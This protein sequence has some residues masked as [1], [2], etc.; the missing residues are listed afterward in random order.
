[1]AVRKLLRRVCLRFATEPGQGA[2]WSEYRG[3]NWVLPVDDT[4]VLLAYD[5]QKQQRSIVVDQVDNNVYELATFDRRV[6]SRPPFLDKETVQDT[7]IWWQKWLFEVTAG[8]I[9]EF[10]KME[11]DSMHLSLR[12]EYDSNRSAAGYGASGLRD[13]FVMGVDIYADGERITPAAKIEDIPENGHIVASGTKIEA[14]R[15]MKVISGTAS[16]FQC[17]SIDQNMIK[18]PRAGS[19][20][21]RHMTE[22]DYQTEYRSPQ[23]LLTRYKTSLYDIARLLQLTGSATKITGPDGR[24]NSALTLNSAVDLENNAIAGDY[25]IMLWTDSL[26]PMS[27]IA[28]VSF[29]QQGDTYGGWMM[30]YSKGGAG[31]ISNLILDSGINIFDVRIYNSQISDNA[32]AAM[33]RDVP[34]NRNAGQQFL[35]VF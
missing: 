14:R 7:E 12:P 31:L 15:I 34:G 3:D 30:L 35:R 33:Y 8:P 1:M 10:E 13:A 6:Y 19:R 20:T 21:E 23:V 18:K 28:T 4:G 29:T 27:T 2:G 5:S 22:M 16:E 24:A 25:T 32:L 17:T 11:D 9:S 26:N